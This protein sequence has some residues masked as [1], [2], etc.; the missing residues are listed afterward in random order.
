MNIHLAGQFRGT[1]GLRQSMEALGVSQIYLRSG[2]LAPHPNTIE[3]GM[4]GRLS[5]A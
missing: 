2:V 4:V 3:Q 1:L 5:A